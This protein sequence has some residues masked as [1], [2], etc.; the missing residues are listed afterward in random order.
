M[1]DLTTST[2]LNP[3]DG[4]GFVNVSS[5]DT[6]SELYQAAPG[7]PIVTGDQLEYTDA[8]NT[9]VATDTTVTQTAAGTIAVRVW[10]DA[11]GVWGSWFDVEFLP[12]NSLT[13]SSTLN[14][15][16]GN[17]H[18][19]VVDPSTAEGSL[20][21]Q[22]SGST[23][24]TG[25][26]LEYTDSPNTVVAANG[27]I[28][29]TVT[30]NFQARLRR[31][32]TGVW[33]SFSII[34]MSAGGTTVGVILQ[35]VD[36]NAYINVS[37]PSTAEGSIFFEHT[38]SAPETGDQVEWDDSPNT[39]VLPDGNFTQTM[40]GDFQAR[41]WRSGSQT[42]SSFAL[43]ETSKDFSV[44]L[45]ER[46]STGTGQ[47]LN[48]SAG[49]ST[50]LS[51]IESTGTGQDLTLSSSD[52]FVVE[53]LPVES[54][55]TLQEL[56]FSEHFSVALGVAE[57]VSTPQTLVLTASLSTALEEATGEGT[58]QE[59]GTVGTGNAIIPLT[60]LEGTG[61]GQSLTLAAEAL[62]ALVPKSTA[63]IGRTLGL[64]TAFS[65][66]LTK[67]ESTGA[68]QD[69]GLEAGT[70]ADAIIQLQRRETT[71]VGRTLG[72]LTE[73]LI[74]FVP[75]ASN[76]TLQEMPLIVASTAVLSQLVSTGTGQDLAL[77]S[78]LSV[79]LSPAESTSTGQ[80]LRAVN[81]HFH[82]ILNPALGVSQGR[83]LALTL[84]E[85]T[86]L[87]SFKKSSIRNITP[88]YATRRLAQKFNIGVL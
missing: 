40:L 73:A 3:V 20:F 74:V 82:V 18:V 47:T 25:D 44:A 62:L 15:V 48:L 38:G 36:G 78:S 7:D 21:A 61:T 5:P 16:E 65:T 84:V 69:L 45:D 43:V 32:S 57:G 26:Q 85:G 33:D 9:T 30:R 27:G 81:D 1:A 66:A 80:E 59:L 35:P 46:V 55:S 4:R 53:L 41:I 83:V 8:A 22:Y 34:S 29:Q 17:A 12:E 75:V 51:I 24:A 14:P 23:P 31:E 52:S 6:E 54:T 56:I 88:V 71:A 42:W 67:A 10:R 13:T 19:N 11:T 37:N 28:T 68:G 60:V 79:E 64:L 63:G 49:I 76:S 87:P 39:D 50:A 70:A 77:S 2:D 86:G 72:L 58:G